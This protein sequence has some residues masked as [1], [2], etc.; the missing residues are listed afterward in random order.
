MRIPHEKTGAART[1]RSKPTAAAA[2]RQGECE[3]ASLVSAA[4]D[5]ARSAEKAG[6]RMRK[7]NLDGYFD[8]PANVV[9]NVALVVNGHTLDDASLSRLAGCPAGGQIAVLADSSAI[10]LASICQG[11]IRKVNEVN[12]VRDEGGFYL[13][14]DYI[15]FAD[16]APEGFGAVAFL[17]M[18]EE[19]S[20]LGMERVELLAAGGNGMKQGPW[21]DDF[22]GYYAWARFGFDANLWTETLAITKDIPE[23]AHCKR[24]SEIMDIDP[25]WWRANGDGCDMV[26]DLAED[27][28]SWQILLKYMED[29]GLLA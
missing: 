19:A 6:V 15:W 4:A 26:F 5:A 27:S 23:L 9:A 21:A 16:N 13:Y 8:K 25:A 10:R 14:L 28:Q 12:I 1:N 22:F 11:L 29:K 17:K 20:S 18:A 2:T 24:L 7:T 3:P